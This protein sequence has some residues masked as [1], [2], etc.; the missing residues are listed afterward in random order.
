MGW[1]G[2]MATPVFNDEWFQHDVGD[3]SRDSEVRFGSIDMPHNFNLVLHRSFIVH[4]DSW[5]IHEL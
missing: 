5:M 4:H 1:D 2:R 3:R